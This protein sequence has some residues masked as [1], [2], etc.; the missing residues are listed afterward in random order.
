MHVVLHIGVG[1]QA[2]TCT[3]QPEPG[4]CQRGCHVGVFRI[5]GRGLARGAFENDRSAVVQRC[6][7]E[8]LIRWCAA[9]GKR[10]LAPGVHHVVQTAMPCRSQRIN[11]ADRT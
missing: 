6:Q 8:L 11:G 3:V 1:Q 9:P 7:I 2:H 5:G 10:R 4:Q